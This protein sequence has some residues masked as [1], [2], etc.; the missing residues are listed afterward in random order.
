MEG[1]GGKIRIKEI[2]SGESAQTN[3][4]YSYI[5]PFRKG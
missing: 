1:R 3:S 2:I 5:L 4:I